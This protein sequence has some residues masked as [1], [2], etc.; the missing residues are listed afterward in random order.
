MTNSKSLLEAY[1]KRM[2][3]A[4]SVYS[5]AHGGERLDQNRKLVLARCLKN[6]DA[7]LTEGFNS[8]QG[9]QRSDMGAWKRFCLNLTTV[10]LPNLIANDLVIVQP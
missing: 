1:S 6:V 5:K 10:A 7:F 8:A 9:T 2:T 4:E 3:I